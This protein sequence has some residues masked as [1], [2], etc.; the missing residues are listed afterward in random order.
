[1]IPSKIELLDLHK[2][3]SQKKIA[4]K[5]NVSKSSVC[6]WFKKYNIQN[7]TSF[8]ETQ[9]LS[10]DVLIELYVNQGLTT[11]EIA[12][13]CGV[14]RVT[15][16][17][18]LK[19]C[20]IPRVDATKPKPV[21]PRDELFS[22]YIEQKKTLEEIGL[23]Y[24]VNRNLV[25]NWL[26]IYNIQIRMYNIRIERPTKEILERLY[27]SEKLTL[28]S[29]ADIWNTNITVVRRWFE[30]YKINTRSNSRKYYH[31][32]A[33]PF[34]KQQREFIVG[35]MLGDGHLA[36]IGK[37][38]SVRLNII[39]SIKQIDYFLWKKEIMGNFINQCLVYKEKKRNSTRI[40]S[41]SIV[42]NE[43]SFYHKLFYDN[44][45]K[46]IKNSLIHYLTP[47]AMAI[48]VMDDGWLNHGINIK[49]SSES[50][51]KKEN[52]ELQLMIKINFNIK[53]KVLEYTRNEK[54]YYYLS[55]NKRNSIL[56]SNMIEPYVID[57]M[58]Y[59][60]VPHDKRD[61]PLLND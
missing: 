15:V 14:C 46:I 55:F 26:S 35:T 51:T 28:S 24:K 42:H 17:K 38:Q 8:R 36:C 34:T 16:G 12:E 21:P 5:Y 22:L 1:M 13:K 27:I 43:F 57:S 19:V 61:S 47:F 44:K 48:W 7:N 29:I 4:E 53:C 33:I 3:L 9:K 25:S 49:I 52:E 39:H 23:I 2:T 60:L 30:K 32:K 10:N 37:K 40:T 41:T 45:K 31:L 56:L 6:R 20:K 11:S 54:K 50:F 18:W 58:K 59:K